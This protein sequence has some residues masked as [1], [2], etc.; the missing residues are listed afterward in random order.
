MK[1]VLQNEQ[2]RH[3]RVN[4]LGFQP[5]NQVAGRLFAAAK[6]RAQ[7]IELFRRDA[8]A[9]VRDLAIVLCQLER[10]ARR[11]ADAD[12][13]R[14]RCD[15]VLAEIDRLRNFLPKAL[16]R[17]LP[18]QYFLDT[19]AVQAQRA[20]G[21]AGKVYR[22]SAVK[23][24][25]LRAGSADIQKRAAA[26]AKLLHRA[27]VAEERFLLAGDNLNEVAGGRVDDGQCLLRV[28]YI[29]QR[30]CGKHADAVDRQR[31]QD[32]AEGQKPGAGALDAL[33][34]EPSVFYV[35]GE[36][37][38]DLFAEKNVE[39]LSLRFVECQVDPPHVPPLFL[40]LRASSRRALSK[41]C[42]F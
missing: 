10:S 23:C 22:R 42:I 15:C 24:D 26:Q 34:A 32:T 19:T 8:V 20:N 16:E 3:Q 41:L 5:Q 31:L 27:R 1:Y 6:E 9:I 37:C 39:A 33:G 35:S 29:A 30:R 18:R 14:V 17:T 21:E 7:R 12:Q 28:G 40:P 13:E 36:P 25:D 11:T 38:H 2:P 4:A